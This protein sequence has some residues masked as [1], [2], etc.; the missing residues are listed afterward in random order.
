[1]LGI[2][3]GMSQSKRRK[4]DIEKDLA[5][6]TLKEEYRRELLPIGQLFP[7]MTCQVAY[8]SY[9]MF[10]GLIEASENPQVSPE[11]P[12]VKCCSKK[13]AAE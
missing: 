11:P 4:C 12:K 7:K 2:Q 10:E 3:N 1:M 5:I 6:E 9:T 13:K 8:G